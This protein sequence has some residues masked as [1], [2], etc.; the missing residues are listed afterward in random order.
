M[1]IPPPAHDTCR[2]CGRPCLCPGPRGITQCTACIFLD[3]AIDGHCA[4]A[5][6]ISSGERSDAGS[7]VCD[8]AS[9]PLWRLRLTISGRPA[10]GDGSTETLPNEPRALRIAR[11]AENTVRHEDV[12]LAWD[13]PGPPRDRFRR[14]LAAAR[15]LWKF[16]ERWRAGEAKPAVTVKFVRMPITIS[17]GD[18][19][20]PAES[21]VERAT[22][23]LAS[24]IERDRRRAEWD[25]VI[26]GV[27]VPRV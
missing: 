15:I 13:E 11:R 24:A 27:G 26:A 2:S 22:M 1:V 20:V 6:A 18:F 5:W 16:R 10:H 7:R 8:A 4:K 17:A 23:T 21:L 12:R 19:A 9:T 3:A 14:V 25:A